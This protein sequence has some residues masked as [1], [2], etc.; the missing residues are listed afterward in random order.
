MKIIVNNEDYII[1]RCIDKA[2]P[3]IVW[4]I[5]EK[6]D[7]INKIKAKKA[8]SSNKVFTL[9]EVAENNALEALKPEYVLINNMTEML[10]DIINYS[11]GYEPDT[12]NFISES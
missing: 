1:D 2:Y 4:S 9:R 8:D 6:R 10:S 3:I 7:I 11:T 12:V 5:S